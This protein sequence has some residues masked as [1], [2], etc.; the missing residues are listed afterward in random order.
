MVIYVGTLAAVA[1]STVV[2][3]LGQG[4]G[5][6]LFAG[7][8][9]AVDKGYDAITDQ[10]TVSVTAIVE[11]DQNIQ[12]ETWVLPEPLTATADEERLLA[13]PYSTTHDMDAGDIEPL[14]SWARGR[15]GADPEVSF[16]K[17][18]VEGRLKSTTVRIVNIKASVVR[19]G[20][21]LAGTLLMAGPQG[22][23]TLTSIGFDLD[24]NE[25]VAR[26]LD[27]KTGKFGS[28]YFS[29]QETTTLS[30]GEQVVFQ[31]TARTERHYVEWC[32]E[33]QLVVD[34]KLESYR[35]CPNGKAMRTTAFHERPGPRGKPEVDPRAY[36][37]LY[38]WAWDIFPNRFMRQDPRT[39]QWR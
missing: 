14:R 7:V 24:E 27:G 20:E 28:P 25:P 23:D 32:V 12:G 38:V 19:R 16:L 22:G 5:E 2:T 30:H 13:N 17:L 10:Q 37:T 26:T 36:Q 31:I 33:L 6:Q 34:R 39:Y 15:G 3:S 11:R 4:A 29:T 35:T 21:P 18:V 9:S 8:R 1:V